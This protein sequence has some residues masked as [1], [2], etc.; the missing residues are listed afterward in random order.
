MGPWK[1]RFLWETIIFRFHVNLRGC[2]LS[3]HCRSISV[4]VVVVAAVVVVVVAVVVVAV[5]VALRYR[6]VC[7]GH[8]LGAD[9]AELVPW[10]RSVRWRYMGWMTAM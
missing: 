7:T 9:V 8:S 2:K 6:L 1:R 4:V 10:E 3:S 5:V